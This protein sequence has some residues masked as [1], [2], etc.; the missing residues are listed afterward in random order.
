MWLWSR[1][2]TWTSVRL[3]GKSLATLE[4]ALA[5]SEGRAHELRAAL[6]AMRDARDAA[7]QVPNA[8]CTVSQHAV[9]KQTKH[10][11]IFCQVGPPVSQ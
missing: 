2:N 1:W 11:L 3:R 4:A 9:V 10:L 6:Q 5:D 8:L 7:N